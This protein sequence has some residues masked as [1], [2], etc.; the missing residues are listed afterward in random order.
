MKLTKSVQMEL[1]FVVAVSSN[2]LDNRRKRRKYWYYVVKRRSQE[3]LSVDTKGDYVWIPHDTVNLYPHL[4]STKWLAQQCA[5][6]RPYASVERY[7]WDV[8]KM[9]SRGKS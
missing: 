4:F 8:D 2:E 5:S 7:L 9:K 1:P 6:S 3:M